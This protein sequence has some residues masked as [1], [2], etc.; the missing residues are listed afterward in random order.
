MT[1]GLTAKIE[2]LHRSLRTAELPHAFG[3]ALALAFCL[4]SPRATVDIDLN[5]FIGVDRVDELV[6][7]LP[8]AVVVDDTNRGQLVRDAQTRAWWD[9]TP[10]DLFLSNHPF[11]DRAEAN[12]R[13]V[14]FAGIP[15]LPVLACS[16]LAVFKA[17]FARPKD[18]VD[19]AAMVAAGAVDLDALERTVDALLGTEDRRQFLD[20]VREFVAEQ[21]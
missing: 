2:E 21:G 13:T 5:V 3:G 1:I 6:A 4:E 20:R 18:A 19:V 12:R 8:D 10:I 9:R 7:A 14:A 11:H 16:D 17:F 15:Q